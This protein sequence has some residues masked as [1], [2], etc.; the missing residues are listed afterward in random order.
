MPYFSSILRIF[1][2]L[3]VFSVQSQAQ[4]INIKEEYAETLKQLSDALIKR[5]ITSKTD[6]GAI[7]CKFCNVLHTRAAEAMYPFSVMYGIKKNK[8][9]LDAA[10]SAANWLMSQQQPDGSWKETPEEW[11]GTTTDQLLMMLL[12]FDK[13]SAS[14]TESERNAWISSMRK[15]ADYL[16]KVMKPEFASIN[17]VATS[18]ATLAKA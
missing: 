13:I 18:T 8:L 1:M 11:T 14:L 2:L 10:K 3:F 6:A 16:A 4:K 9:Y 5:Q 12:T 7:Q 15:A 17:Y